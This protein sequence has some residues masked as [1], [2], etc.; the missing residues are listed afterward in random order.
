MS[1]FTDAAGSADKLLLRY[2]GDVGVSLQHVGVLVGRNAHARLWPQI[3][4]WALRCAGDAVHPRFDAA[5]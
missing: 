3:T 4:R 5:A 1:T 2:E